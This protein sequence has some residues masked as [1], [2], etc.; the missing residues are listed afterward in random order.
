MIEQQQILKDHRMNII[1]VGTG[2]RAGIC[3]I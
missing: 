3:G 2:A 1:S